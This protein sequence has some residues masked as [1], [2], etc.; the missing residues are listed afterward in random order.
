[1]GSPK[2]LAGAETQ[3]ANKQ[4]ALNTESKTRELGNHKNAYD[5][6]ATR[7]NALTAYIAEQESKS[8][9]YDEAWAKAKVERA[10]VFTNMVR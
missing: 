5:T 4:P 3:L 6:E 7:R 10:D 8:L 9:S 1:L 2:D